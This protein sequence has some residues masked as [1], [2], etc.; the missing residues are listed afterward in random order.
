V[1]ALD[2]VKNGSSHIVAN[3]NTRKTIDIPL[4][5]PRAK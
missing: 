2:H 1:L 5:P 3:F 4:A